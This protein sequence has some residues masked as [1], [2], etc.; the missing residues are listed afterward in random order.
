M[1]LGICDL[2]R[3][4]KRIGLSHTTESPLRPQQP[5]RIGDRSALHW[6]L[7]L[8]APLAAALEASPRWDLAA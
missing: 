2:Y 7:A 1:N 5:P 4:R 8:L 3:L 6:A